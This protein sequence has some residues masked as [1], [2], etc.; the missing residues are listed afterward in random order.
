MFLYARRNYSHILGLPE[1]ANTS[2]Y[3][4]PASM[5][6]NMEPISLKGLSKTF[7]SYGDAEIFYGQCRSLEKKMA[8]DLGEDNVFVHVVKDGP[9]DI[10]LITFW[11]PEHSA[12]CSQLCSRSV[13]AC[14]V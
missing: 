8:A 7:I 12:I 5:H 9:R 10:M 6:S 11:E 13:I 1:A 3:L 14:V 4:S 2:R